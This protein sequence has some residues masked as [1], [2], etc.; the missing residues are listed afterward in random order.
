MLAGSQQVNNQVWNKGGHA[1]LW[2]PQWLFASD[3]ATAGAAEMEEQSKSE[4]KHMLI[5][6]AS[7]LV[8]DLYMHSQEDQSQATVS[9][10]MRR[11]HERQLYR[12]M[13]SI[14]E[15]RPGKQD[16]EEVTQKEKWSK[17]VQ[18][19]SFIITIHYCSPVESKCSGH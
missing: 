8:W 10:V 6:H 3:N 15:S 14:A 4:L 7:L 2:E 19:F 18:I 5:I 16:D 11:V 9:E 1:D 17:E 13:G 12:V